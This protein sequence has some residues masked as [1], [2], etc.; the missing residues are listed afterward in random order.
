MTGSEYWTHPDR[1]DKEIKTKVSEL[2]GWHDIC[3][4]TVHS[5]KVPYGW[6]PTDHP[7]E[8]FKYE[9]PLPDYPQDLNAIHLLITRLDRQISL[10]ACYLHE[11]I[12]GGPAGEEPD[13]NGTYYIYSDWHDVSLTANATARQRCIAYI[14]T[15]GD[16]S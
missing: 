15:K 10:F 7:K 3:Y 6:H 8:D 14:L 9:H 11:V 12:F 16:D 2:A 13:E 5:S 4:H 1:T